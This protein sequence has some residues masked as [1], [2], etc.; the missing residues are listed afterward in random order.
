MRTNFIFVTG[1]TM[2][3]VG[4]GVTTASMANILKSKGYSVTIAKADPYLNID[5]GTMNPTEH[6][7]VA[8]LARAYNRTPYNGEPGVFEADQDLGT[9]ER[10]I[11]GQLAGINSITTGQVYRDVL[12]GERDG[13][14]NGRTVEAIPGITDE[15]KKRIRFVGEDSGADFVFV[16]IGGTVGEYQNQLFYRAARMMKDERRPGEKVRFVHV[17]SVPI[18]ETLGEQKTKPTQRSIEDLGALRITPD[19]LVCRS[20][21]PL[22]D[23]RKEK[24]QT[25]CG[26]NRRRILSNPDVSSVYKVPLVLEEQGFGGEMLKSLSMQARGEDMNEWKALVERL[27]SVSDPVDIVMVGKYF[28]SGES[29]FGDSYISV[30]E[31][32]K[33]AAWHNDRKPSISWVNSEDLETGE[34]P[35]SELD[36]YEG[37]VVPGGY[38]KRGTEGIIK[39]VQY[40]REHDMPYLGLC[41]GLQMS[42]IETARNVCGLGAANTTECDPRTPHPVVTQLTEQREVTALGGTQ[43]LGNYPCDMVPGT[44]AWELYGRAAAVEERHRHRWEVNPEYHDALRDHGYVFSGWSPDRRLVEIGER[45]DCRLH[46]GSQFHPEFTSTPLRPNPLFDG[47]VRAAIGRFP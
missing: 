35:M 46:I 15:I 7:E 3:G 30:I 33:S 27:D 17:D 23:K 14:Y 2:S 39:A 42:I 36:R 32:I 4:K 10:F 24:L 31:A 5:A 22:D 9:Y 19:F 16:E 21:R 45:K 44:K 41:Y 6:G 29:S 20:P 28:K 37:M 26:I 40:A 38:G 18:P 34:L 43:R 8:V 25:M 11:G 13:R 47:L 1:G 12:K